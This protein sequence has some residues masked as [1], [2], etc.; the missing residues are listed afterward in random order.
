[1]K[2]IA[3]CLLLFAACSLAPVGLARET[4]EASQYGT[5]LEDLLAAF[6][7]AGVPC[8]GAAT[9][10]AEVCFRAEAV[11]ASYLAERLDELLDTYGSAGLSSGE[12][13]AANGVWN[14]TLAY[15][16]SS[17]G[18]LD[19]YLAEAPDNCVNGIVRLVSPR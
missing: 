9:A 6:Y 2:R 3:T 16:N 12:W 5:V 18:Y 4:I 11:S 19:L 17:Y 8:E 14:V 7:A 1:M 13:R 10:T 15:P